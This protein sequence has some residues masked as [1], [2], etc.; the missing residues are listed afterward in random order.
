MSFI[1]I[2][3]IISY[4]VLL[5]IVGTIVSKQVQTNKD[6]LAGGDGFGILTAAVGRTAN[7]AGGPATVGNATY[8]FQS[9]LGGSWFAI[10]NIIGMWVAAP[11]APRMYR[12]MKRGDTITIGGYIGYRF[13]KFSKV[14]AGITNFLA[15][16]GFVASNILATG[17]FLSIILGWDFKTSMIITAIIVTLYT[18]SGG[19]KSV[20]QINIIQVLIMIIGFSFILLP[21]SLSAVG[22]WNNLINAVP[23]EFLNF[24][25]MGWGVIIG[26][27]II[28]TALTGFT[29]QAG[30]IGVASSKSLDVSW[31]STLLGGVFYVFIAIPVIFV[32]MVAF[33]LFP[34]ANAQ[35]ILA[36]SIVE[37]LPTGLIGILVAAVISATMSTAASCAL[38]AVTCFSIDVLEP[39]RGKKSD[40]K[41]GLKLTRMLIV[42]ISVIATLFAVLLPNVIK[43]LLMGYSLAAGGLLVP[44]FATM[45]WKRATKEGITAAML[46]GGISYLILES[47]LNVNWP[48]LFLSIPLSLAL[49]VVVSL[50]TK[51]QELEKYAPYFEDS[52]QEYIKLK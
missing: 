19:L 5:V 34:D 24:N 33:L 16:T 25:S 42:I 27:I 23:K 22:G 26:T 45:F 8:G 44:A 47:F 48:P 10:S 21:S 49:V 17:T 30:Y 9:G 52:W 31:K 13:G 15:Y 46:G 41:E 7:M 3:V 29:T 40:E 12:A 20:F 43:L 36:R 35:N 50:L 6:A 11:F 18:L 1:D 51:P 38:N 39:I 28:P 37:I 2:A 14:F 4:F 32:G